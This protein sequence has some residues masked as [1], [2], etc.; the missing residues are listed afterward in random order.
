MYGMDENRFIIGYL[1]KAVN[2]VIQKLYGMEHV[3]C[4]LLW[5]VVEQECLCFPRLLFTKVPHTAWA[6]NDPKA[7]SAYSSND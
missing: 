7:V 4:F 3:K 5:N 6:T 2:D 1:A